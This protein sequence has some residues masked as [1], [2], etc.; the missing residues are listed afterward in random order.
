MC[1]R[2]A[3]MTNGDC[4][5]VTSQ[6]MFFHQLKLYR[7]TQNRMIASRHVMT[8]QGQTFVFNTNSCTK[9]VFVYLLS[10]VFHSQKCFWI[11]SN[12][13]AKDDTLTIRVCFITVIHNIIRENHT[14]HTIY[15][16][17]FSYARKFH[18]K[19]LDG[20]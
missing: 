11:Q 5:T 14:I 4:V 1:M 15:Y 6:K 12:F 17:L 8:S 3:T 10:F 20:K 2:M 18:C 7:K 13:V 16:F 19:H 9:N